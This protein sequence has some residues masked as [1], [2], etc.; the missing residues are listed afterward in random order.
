MSENASIT[1]ADG[2][3]LF[4]LGTR[5]VGGVV[6]LGLTIVS[7]P[8][9]ILPYNTRVRVRRGFAELARGVIALP[10]E[11]ADIS[12]RVVDDIFSGAAPTLPSAET[13][14]NRARAFTERLSRAADEFGATVSQAAGR[15]VDGVEKSAAKVDEWVE[16]APKTP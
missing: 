16:K 7:I 5:L 15:A 12:E 14:S 13:I 2:D 8:L 6:R 10:K 11:L 4:E 9:S 3:G 1:R